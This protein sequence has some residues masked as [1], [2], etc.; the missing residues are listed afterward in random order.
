MPRP[1]VQ[2]T[3]ST[4]TARVVLDGDLQNQRIRWSITG[5]RLLGDDG[6]EATFERTDGAWS[7]GAEL[8]NG[9]RVVDQGVTRGGGAPL[10]AATWDRAIVGGD[11]PVGASLEV[12]GGRGL[13]RLEPGETV[14]VR[15]IAPDGVVSPWSSATTGGLPRAPSRVLSLDPLACGDRDFPRRVGAGHVTCST[16]DHDAAL[17][18]WLGPTASAP[19]LIADLPVRQGKS[20][21]EPIPPWTAAVAQGPARRLVWTSDQAGSWLPGMASMTP[22]GRREVLGR[23]ASDGRSV[24]FAGRD[25]L[26]VGQLGGSQRYQIPARPVHTEH[27]VAVGGEWVAVVEGPVGQESLRLHHISQHRGSTI[28]NGRPRSPLLAG[29]WLSWQGD[30][31]IEALS[32][33]GGWRRTWTVAAADGLPAALD[34]WLIVARRTGGLAALH[35]PTGVATVLE[36]GSGLLE[37]RGASAGGFTTWL[38]QAGQPGRMAD[39]QASQRIFEED[40]AAAGGDPL[41]RHPGGHGG[42][43]GRLAEG[44]TRWVEVD[45]GPG[46]WSVDVWVG[47]GQQGPAPTVERGGRSIA[48][49]GLVTGPAEGEPGHW[50]SIGPPLASSGRGWEDRRI[51]II[52]SGG[53]GGATVDAMRLRPTSE[54]R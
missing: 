26:E 24:V 13:D 44:T 7:I 50:V 21:A 35:L 10:L 38:R 45:P 47:E 29:G 3:G 54:V 4:L 52:W 18:R 23:P 36:T 25:R 20:E 9:S 53:P 41:A 27:P 16:G 30:G 39:W 19:A 5:A 37:L 34:D 43:H 42:S 51:R 48:G 49:V 1:V 31:E 14:S 6:T 28:A 8:V 33:D 17:D 11:A 15:W 40:G 32:V 22:L 12:Y 2:E 46:T